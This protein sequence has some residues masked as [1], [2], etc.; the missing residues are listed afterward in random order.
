MSIQLKPGARLFSAACDTQLIVVKAP[1]FPVDLTVGGHPVV[2]SA[3]DKVAGIALVEGS[4]TGTMMGKRYVNT[5]GSLELLCTK[6]GKG[7]LSVDG[8]PCELKDA[9]PLPSSD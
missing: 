9:K 2:T 8:Q 7:S 1:A 3:A 5:D 6:P 4:D